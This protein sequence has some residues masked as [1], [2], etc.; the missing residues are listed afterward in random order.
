MVVEV[1]SLAKLQIVCTKHYSHDKST[2]HGAGAQYAALCQ[3]LAALYLELSSRDPAAGGAVSE[4]AAATAALRCVLA[5]NSAAK[6]VLTRPELDSVWNAIPLHCCLCCLHR[7]VKQHYAVTGNNWTPLAAK[8]TNSPPHLHPKPPTSLSPHK[9][10]PAGSLFHFPFAISAPC[11]SFKTWVP[12][13][14][15]SSPAG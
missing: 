2:G 11:H 6:V 14:M 12:F 9:G 13:P 10:M 3:G 1:I 7:V 4:R 8:P 15:F 5:F